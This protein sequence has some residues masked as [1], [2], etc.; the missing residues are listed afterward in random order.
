MALIVTGTAGLFLYIKGG[1]PQRLSPAVVQLAAGEQ[2]TNPHRAQCD[3]PDFKRFAQDDICQLNPGQNIAPTIMVWGDS[4]AD[5]L[6]PAFFELAAQYGVNGYVATAH[7]CP[8]MLGYAQR[9]YKGFDCPAFNQH[10]FDLVTRHNIKQVFL[11]GNWTDHFRTTNGN[12][13]YADMNWYENYKPFYSQINMAALKRT[14]E[15][16]QAQGV[17]VYVVVDTPYAPVDPPRHL[18]MRALYHLPYESIAI[19]LSSYL[20]GRKDNI[21][22]FMS[23]SAEDGITFID[24][25]EALCN[26]EQCLMQHDNRSLYYNQGHMSAYGAHYLAPLF[27]PYIS[28]RRA[29]PVPVR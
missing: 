20:A 3:K 18:S 15:L 17:R 22:T 21:D 11:L 12:Y 23:I 26:R 8:P 2:D 25:R 13:D 1:I 10:V 6:A 5:A 7:G 14:I 27:A 4:M 29:P 16:L 28:A 9:V 24:P 19:P